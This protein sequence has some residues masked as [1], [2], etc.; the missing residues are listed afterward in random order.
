M[1]DGGKNNRPTG[2]GSGASVQPINNIINQNNLVTPLATD[3]G[4]NI[5]HIVDAS[6]KTPAIFTTTGAGVTTPVPTVIEP[7]PASPYATASDLVAIDNNNGEGEDDD[8]EII[9]F[10]LYTND[11]YRQQL[12]QEEADRI[13][14]QEKKDRP[15]E[16]R[17]VDGELRF[18]DD[19]EDEKSKERDPNLVEGSYLPEY[20]QHDFPP[21]FIGQPIEEIDP[22]IKDKVSSSLAGD[23]LVSS[24]TAISNTGYRP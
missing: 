12:E 10:A 18:D 17:L 1:K 8:D 11:S 2:V 5:S 23:H 19:D 16:G 9:T 22:N 14:A 3:S 13:R 7:P 24:C 6:A 20:M 15:A 4:S 21:E